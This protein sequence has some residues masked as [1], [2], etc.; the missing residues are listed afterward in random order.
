MV[1]CVQVRFCSPEAGDATCPACRCHPVGRKSDRP[2]SDNDVKELHRH[3]PGQP[4]ND[5]Q[6]RDAPPRRNTLQLGQ[7]PVAHVP[8]HARGRWGSRLRNTGTGAM[9]WKRAAGATATDRSK[10]PDTRLTERIFRTPDCATSQREE[11]VRTRCWTFFRAPRSEAARPKLS[12]P[13]PVFAQASG[14]FG[15][16]CSHEVPGARLAAVT[17]LSRSSS[18]ACIASQCFRLSAKHMTPRY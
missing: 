7:Q 12:R 18:P 2:R 17:G 16:S 4:G 1:I 10:A 8:D 11:D 14:T 13:V 3:E 6:Q 15:R 9:P 5:E